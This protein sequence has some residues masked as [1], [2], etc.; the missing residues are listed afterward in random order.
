VTEVSLDRRLLYEAALERK[1][2][3]ANGRA[4]AGDSQGSATAF[5]ETADLYRHLS[6]LEKEPRIRDQRIRMASDFDQRADRARAAP[7]G[8]SQT[9]GAEDAGDLDTQIEGMIHESSVS[10]DDIHGLED[11]KREIKI[12]YGLTLARKPG[13]VQLEGWKSILLYGPPGNG[14]TMLA[15]A[16]S[17]SME[18]TFFDVS[19]GEI[20]SKYFGE[21]SKLISALYAA[22]RRRS[23]AVVFL[24]E[25]DALARQRSGDESGVERRVLSTLLTELDGL[26]NKADDSYVLTIASTN[27]PWSLDAAIL[28]RFQKKVLVPL[29]DYLAIGAI[30]KHLIAGRGL[31]ST[32]PYR[33]LSALLAG[34]SGREISA[35]CQEAV[36]RMVCSMNPDIAD[37]VDQG[38]ASVREYTLALRP[39]TG[40]DI[41]DSLRLIPPATHSEDLDRY[42][43]WS[44]DYR[45]LR[46]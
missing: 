12:A 11:T 16:A 13:E 36:N 29:P 32:V 30:L 2:A 23:P 28:S 4:K 17:G 25:F 40:Q 42:S 35:V 7:V 22:A 21:S 37:I 20:L 38:V 44:G 41:E 3:I 10:W 14:K 46:N 34:R 9:Q 27:V 19:V 8:D 15:A 45:R 31:E 43:A 26:S 18:A 33:E 6:Q 5:A 39:L 24:D 1:L